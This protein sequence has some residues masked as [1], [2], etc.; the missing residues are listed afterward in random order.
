MP[1]CLPGGVQTLSAPAPSRQWELRGGQVRLTCHT[2]GDLVKAHQLVQQLATSGVQHPA[3]IGTWAGEAQDLALVKEQL[4]R[5]WYAAAATAV[6]SQPAQ[7]TVPSTGR[8]PTVEE[9]KVEQGLVC[10][11]GWPRWHLGRPVTVFNLTVKDATQ[12][13]LG[14]A[15]TARRQKF[16]EYVSEATG[17]PQQISRRGLGCIK[18]AQRTLWSLRWDNHYKEIYWRLP[19]NGL[20]TAARMHDAQAECMCGSTAPGRQHHYWD[21]PIAAAVVQNIT[22]NLPAAWCSRPATRPALL[23][24]HLWLMQTPAGPRRMYQGVWKVVCLAALNAMDVGRKAALDFRMQHRAPHP[25]APAIAGQL[26]ITSM[27]QPA[28][29]TPHQQQHNQQVQQRRQQQLRQETARRLQD[30]KQ[31]AVA[32]FWELLSDFVVM[33]AAPDKWVPRVAV[34]HPFLCTEPLINHIVLAPR[35]A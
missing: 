15:R 28:V 30:A 26:S 1:G 10:R 3:G 31:K 7:T 11:L 9:Q 24:E 32:R 19:L 34:D 20:C 21:C 17:Q 13:Q 16:Q 25:A 27:L 33:H 6:Q 35:T 18:A 23:R 5:G 29:P 12:L 4:P 8:D 14:P 22:A 2:V